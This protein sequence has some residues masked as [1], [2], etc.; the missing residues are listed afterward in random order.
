MCRRGRSAVDFSRLSAHTPQSIA[1]VQGQLHTYI[2]TC[3]RDQPHEG[4]SID[5]G[6]RNDKSFNKIEIRKGL[7]KHSCGRLWDAGRNSK[8]SRCAS[9]EDVGVFDGRFVCPN[10]R[11]MVSSS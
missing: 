9:A 2:V 10:E 4:H 3:A 6:D 1:P 11:R 8:I 5:H 7:R